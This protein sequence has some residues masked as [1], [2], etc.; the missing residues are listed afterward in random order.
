MFSDSRVRAAQEDWLGVAHFAVGAF[1]ADAAR[2]GASAEIT[3]LVGDLSKT[4]AEFDALDISSHG[5]G[6]KRLRH[7]GSGP[8]RGR[9]AH[10]VARRRSRQTARVPRRKRLTDA[11][12]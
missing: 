5:E 12:S 4:S 7:P 6:V 3:Q 11:S 10:W 2:A 8:S 1:R 9:S